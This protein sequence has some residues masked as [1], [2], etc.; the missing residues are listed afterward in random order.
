MVRSPLEATHAA[1]DTIVASCVV[2]ALDSDS[3]EPS[4]LDAF[5]WHIN[6]SGGLAADIGCGTGRVAA[7]LAAAGLDA[8]GIDL[9]PR[10]VEVARGLYPEPRFCEGSML[11]RAGC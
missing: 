2:P 8:F 11:R 5:V 1:C 3:V 10:M 9:S 6:A 4:P 7:C